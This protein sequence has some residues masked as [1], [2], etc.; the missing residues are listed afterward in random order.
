MLNHGNLILNMRKYMNVIQAIRN[1]GDVLKAWGGNDIKESGSLVKVNSLFLVRPL[2]II[3]KKLEYMD[4]KIMK[5]IIDA[6]LKIFAANYIQA[7]KV[8]LDVYGEDNIDVLNV[9][10][11]HNPNV[12]EMVRA[13]L[14]KVSNAFEEIDY[15]HELFND[16]NTALPLTVAQE[17]SNSSIVP[18]NMT[19]FE[20]SFIQTYDIEITVNA[21]SM[22]KATM[23]SDGSM[24]KE[25]KNNKRMLSMPLTI[26]PNIVFTDSNTLIDN[27]LSEEE[28]ASFFNR[29]EAYRA[30]AI[31]L[32]DLI[33]ATDLVKKAK[34]KKIKNR[35]DVAKMLKGIQLYSGIDDIMNNKRSFSKNYNIYILDID[36]KRKID[37]ILKSNVFGAA[38]QKALSAMFAFSIG[39]VD[40]SKERLINIIDSIDGFSSIPFR[41]LKRD[42]ESDDISEIFKNLLV[43]KQPF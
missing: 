24:S 31:N 23:N 17:A 14:D 12:R 29:F 19:K 36:D 27:L 7:F 18:N 42:K 41:M 28:D 11:N 26:F 35:N 34:E 2:L 3:S 40:T 15:I 32:S 30:G 37:S 9:L 10:N 38:K 43:G 4:P 21:K 39:F 16:K 6:E 25:F 33:F 8:L 22:S 5:G 1:G 13:T 20:Q